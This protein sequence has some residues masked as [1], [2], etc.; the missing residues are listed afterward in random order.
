MNMNI[1]SV[2][3]VCLMS[4]M[5]FG[6]NW[7]FEGKNR[8]KRKAAATAQTEQQQADLEKRT[9]T[10]SDL[11]IVRL[12]HD[13]EGQDFATLAVNNANFLLTTH[14]KKDLP[15]TLYALEGKGTLRR[16]IL[17][18][19][20]QS[21][22]LYSD[23]Q[24]TPMPM[25][26]LPSVGLY[27]VQMLEFI[28]DNTDGEVILG[29]Y[30]A[31]QIGTYGKGPENTAIVLYSYRKTYVPMGIYEKGAFTSLNNMPTFRGSVKAVTPASNA[32]NLAN[33]EQLYVLE[34]AYQQVVF[35]SLGGSITEVNLPFKSNDSKSIVLPIGVDREI[36]KNSPSNALFPSR[37]AIGANGAIAPKLGGYYPL[38]RRGIQRPDGKMLVDVPSRFYA[39]NVISDTANMAGVPFRMN[40]MG[41]D[42]IEF[43]GNVDGRRITKRFQFAKNAPYCLEVSID[44]GTGTNLWLT[45]GVPDVEIISN[46]PAPALKYR[47]STGDKTVVEKIKLPKTSA[48]YATVSPDWVCNSNGYFGMLIDPL[49]SKGAGFQAN[50]VPGIVDPTRLSALKNLY[51]PEKYPGYEMLMAIPGQTSQHTFR[52]FA[53]P[54]ERDLLA[55]LDTLYTDPQTG[56]NPDYASAWSFHGWFKAIS[57]PFAK[58]LFL[59]MQL[60]HKITGSWGFSIILLTVILRLMLY[61]LNAWSI[62]STMR[63]QQ[64]QPKMAELQAKMK[65]DP[66][67]ARLEM[68]QLYKQHKVNPLTGGCLP[69]L[70][71]M[72]FLIGMFDLLK[73]AFDLRGASFIPGWIDNLT[74]PDM[75]F[76]WNF[77]IPFIGT[78]FHLLPILLGVIMYFNQRMMMKRKMKKG[79]EMDEKAKQMQAMGKFMPI[80]FTVIFYNFP[81]GLNIYWMASML[82]GMVQQWYMMKKQATPVLIIEPEPPKKKTSKRRR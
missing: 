42:F 66:Q 27:D 47:A 72:P 19:S 20:N 1:R 63:M 78:S 32:P 2:L 28:D 81:S 4:L 38:L 46:R 15:K 23:G 55:K 69:M 50:F 49:S 39:L 17:S 59:L 48:M 51:P 45:S 26:A 41:E 43:T 40:A 9:A 37:E 21:L 74:A 34:N 64:L 11:P 3:F 24:E 56:D 36:E 31:S 52:L 62:R 75:L 25:I 73:S 14:W 33:N 35:S 18:Q 65:K 6:M 79:E 5:L 67:R 53:G 68:M 58:F 16:V 77:S 12:Y 54:F 8:E 22:A 71:Q 57:E 13:E 61:P 80:I 10:L 82:L 70:I 30:N 29:E 60:F 76:S 44:T 7:F